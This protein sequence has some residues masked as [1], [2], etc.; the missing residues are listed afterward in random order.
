M[1]NLKDNSNSFEFLMIQNDIKFCN[2][3]I[4][5]MIASPKMGILSFSFLPYLSLFIVESFDYLN[6]NRHEYA[7]LIKP[8]YEDVLRASRV[9]VKLFEEDNI[10]DIISWISEDQIAWYNHDH[11]GSFGWLKR[12]IQSDMGLFSYHNHIISTTH[13]ALLNLGVI[14]EQQNTIASSFMNNLSFLSLSISEEIGRYISRLYLNLIT[15]SQNDQTLPISTYKITSEFVTHK[16]VKARTYYSSTFNGPASD[17]VNSGLL[18]LLSA[19]NFFHKIMDRMSTDKND[20]LLKF[21]FITL[22]HAIASIERLKNRYWSQ[23][24]LSD[25]S[26]GFLKAILTDEEVKFI[27]STTKLRNIL[28]HYS[29]EGVPLAKLNLNTRLFGLVEYCYKGLSAEDLESLLDRQLLR[30]LMSLEE[31]LVM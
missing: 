11:N 5:S 23:G 22:Y 10:A 13:I 14:K 27:T 15:T 18:L 9:R 16:D 6:V 25:R 21:K 24:L 17:Q 3:L 20:T 4:H 2:D 26:K 31:W 28:V 7:Q 30:I 12:I 19:L 1:T 29:M 8:Q